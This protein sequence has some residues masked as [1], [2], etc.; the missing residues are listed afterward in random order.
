MRIRMRPIRRNRD[1]GNAPDVS[2]GREAH[3]PVEHARRALARQT[4]EL[5]LV[6]VVVVI[7]VVV[8]VADAGRLPAETDVAGCK[9][10]GDIV[11]VVRLE[12]RLARDLIGGGGGGERQ[13]TRRSRMIR[14][15][16]R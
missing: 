6:L 4:P 14:S 3:A 1:L 15:R 12:D 8:A 7:V 16:R 5:R 10:L 13:S 11:W 9:V 2:V